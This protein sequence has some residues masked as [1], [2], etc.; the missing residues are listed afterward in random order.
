MVYPPRISIT[1]RILQGILRMSYRMFA[2]RT[3]KDNLP[4][5]LPRSSLNLLQTQSFPQRSPD[6]GC[7]LIF[8]R[9]VFSHPPGIRGSV[10][11]LRTRCVAIV[12]PESALPPERHIA[13]WSLARRC[14]GVSNFHVRGRRENRLSFRSWRRTVRR[15][16]RSSPSIS[17]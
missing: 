6:E 14:R 9:S 1:W 10:T 12:P 3:T 15:E 17:N 4:W 2:R 16:V 5:W 13:H 7:P 11:R 8:A